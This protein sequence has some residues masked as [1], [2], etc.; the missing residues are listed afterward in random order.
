MNRVASFLLGSI[1]ALSGSDT[2]A[3]DRTGERNVQRV[4]HEVD[5]PFATLNLEICLVDDVPLG[6][7]PCPCRLSGG[8]SLDVV[9][10]RRRHMP[11]DDIQGFVHAIAHQGAMQ[12]PELGDH[13]FDCH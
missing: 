1:L 11:A 9:P 10:G 4:V 5:D 12:G 3:N 6:H 13:V 7:A 8:I 2:A